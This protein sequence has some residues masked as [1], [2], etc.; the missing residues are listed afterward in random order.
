MSEPFMKFPPP[1]DPPR[2]LRETVLARL[3]RV[4]AQ[5]A[6]RRFALDASIACLSAV[7]LVLT[8][9]L[10]LTEMVGS[11][12]LQYL[13]LFFTDSAAALTYW[14]ESLLSFVGAFPALAA[15]AP[16]AAV[17]ALLY[18]LKRAVID[19]ASAFHHHKLAA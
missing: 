2:G 19:G 10:F 15:A 5:R 6:W 13:S 7:A 3:E 4:Q 16:L 11:G 17:L 18:S 12:A 14:K 9:K 8:A 1:V